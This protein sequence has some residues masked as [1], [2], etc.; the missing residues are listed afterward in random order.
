MSRTV[1][2]DINVS[3][4]GRDD[5]LILDTLEKRR[6]HASYPEMC[7]IRETLPNNFY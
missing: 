3:M 1:G 4:V 2:H 5:D 6:Y 7:L